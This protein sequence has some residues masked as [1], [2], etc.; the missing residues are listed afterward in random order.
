MCG[1]LH[2][3]RSYSIL[4]DYFL[5]CVSFTI[6]VQTHYH[7]IPFIIV[8]ITYI[9]IISIVRLYCMCG[10]YFILYY[11]Y[12]SPLPSPPH[13]RLWRK[14]STC[15][16]SWIRQPIPYSGCNGLPC[17]LGFWGCI[18]VWP[19][20]GPSDHPL[21]PQIYSC[22]LCLLDVILSSAHHFIYGPGVFFCF[23]GC[24]LR[25]CKARLGLKSVGIFSCLGPG[26]QP[27][28]LGTNPDVACGLAFHWCLLWACLNLVR[29]SVSLVLWLDQSPFLP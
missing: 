27:N 22:I 23:L 4:S 17:P 11:L 13:V 3:I 14:C 9:S 25:W 20:F 24:I 2:K 6:N 19:R 29:A 16:F 28:F 7:F 18:H 5:T 15:I 10:S 8:I 1:W 26:V 12:C 21:V